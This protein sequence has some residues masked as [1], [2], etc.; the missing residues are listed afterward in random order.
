MRGS[1]FCAPAHLRTRHGCLRIPEVVRLRHDR[2]EALRQSSGSMPMWSL[3]ATRSFCL[4]PRYFSVVWTLTCPKRNWICSSPCQQ[5]SVNSL[6][7]P[8]VGSKMW[9]PERRVDI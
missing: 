3:T 1:S 6:P 9:L 8:E 7:T 2:P 5:L 4:H